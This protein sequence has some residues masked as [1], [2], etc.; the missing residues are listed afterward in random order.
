MIVSTQARIIMEEYESTYRKFDKVG[1]EPWAG[2]MGMGG[3][4]VLSFRYV[5][6]I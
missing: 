3:R 4:K 1:R 6:Q 2:S 5:G